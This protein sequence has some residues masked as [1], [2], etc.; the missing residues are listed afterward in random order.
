MMPSPADLT[1]FQA[2]ALAGN[3]SRASERLG[4]SQPSL[5]LAMQ[6]LEHS[7]GTALFIRSKKGVT[8]TPA[9]RQLLSHSRDLL[10]RW[11]LLK[12]RALA[13]THEIQGTFSLGCHPSVALYSLD[14]LPLLLERHPA[15]ELKLVHDLSRNI[16]QKV[17]QLE[18][19]VGIVVNPLRHPD[20]MIRKLCHDEVTLWVGEGHRKLQDVH[21][22]EAMLI[23]DP[24]LLQT[25]DILKK[26]KRA[27]V[28]FKRTLTSSNLEVI[29][30]LAA[31]GAGVAILPGRVAAQAKLKKVLKAP[32]FQDDISLLYRME[33]KN[34]KS[35]QAITEQ[36]AKSFQL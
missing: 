26:L 23:C 3:L 29:T 25:Q 36:I 2:V 13:S 27:G 30:S 33:N 20:L 15:L 22:G 10:Q 35:I 5:T 8:L 6:R 17:I 12:G 32:I 34:I 16:A 28:Q 1:Y 19:D 14:F 7:I 24:D 21:S 18:V 4:V 11:D 31:N 9:G